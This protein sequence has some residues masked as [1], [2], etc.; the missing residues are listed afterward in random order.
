MAQGHDFNDEIY[1]PPDDAGENRENHR[2]LEKD[3]ENGSFSPTWR[4]NSAV[5]GLYPFFTRHTDL[6]KARLKVG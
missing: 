5:P 2:E 1:T 3:R 4:I 6:T